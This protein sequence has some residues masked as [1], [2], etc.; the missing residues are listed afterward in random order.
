MSLTYVQA[1][2]HV[3]MLFDVWSVHLKCRGVVEVVGKYL[4]YGSVT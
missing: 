3:E 2:K 1:E 4:N